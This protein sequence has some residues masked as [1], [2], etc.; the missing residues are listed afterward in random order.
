MKTK[1]TKF[2]IFH[3]NGKAEI[4]E[5]AKVE[6]AKEKDGLRIKFGGRV[7]RGVVCMIQVIEPQVVN[8]PEQDNEDDD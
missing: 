3:S 4:I 1:K 5:S 2:K 8:V 7:I 6:W